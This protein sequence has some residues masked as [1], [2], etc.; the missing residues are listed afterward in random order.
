MVG[1]QRFWFHHFEN[2][3]FLK[4]L[5]IGRKNTSSQWLFPFREIQPCKLSLQGGGIFKASNDS[6]KRCLQL[7]K[8]KD[9]SR[10]SALVQ[11]RPLLA[12]HSTI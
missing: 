12:S 2:T 1:Q 11:S 9:S 8:S 6:M 7:G 3:F 4:K 10:V 5:N